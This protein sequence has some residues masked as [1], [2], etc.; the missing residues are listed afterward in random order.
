MSFQELF[1]EQRRLFLLQL[2]EAGGEANDKILRDGLNH[3]KV[4]SSLDQTRTALAWL[5]EQGLIR[6]ERISDDVWGAS[7]TERGIDVALG[8]V[9]VPGVKRPTRRG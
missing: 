3:Y 8:R 6:L 5:D 2:L 9:V 7:I 1:T 4:T